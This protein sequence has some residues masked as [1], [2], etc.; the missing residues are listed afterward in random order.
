M[1]GI[2]PSGY[3][4]GIMLGIVFPDMVERDHAGYS[5]PWLARR[6]T[7]LGIC[8]LGMLARYPSW[9]VHPGIYT[10]PGTPLYHTQPR[11][12]RRTVSGELGTGAKTEG[13][14]TNS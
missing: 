3:E 11:S 2:D 8:L 14:I 13:F 1:L 5:P 4:R 7:M 6:G 12:T 10:L 9:Y